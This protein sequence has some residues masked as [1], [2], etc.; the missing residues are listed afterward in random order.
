M[1]ATVTE[2]VAIGGCEDCNNASDPIT[3]EDIKD[4]PSE[5][6]FKVQDKTVTHCFDIRALHQYYEKCGKLENPLN[7]SVFSEETLDEFLK[8]IIQLGLS[9]EGEQDEI[10]QDR[11]RQ[12]AIALNGGEDDDDDFEIVTTVYRHGAH[13]R[14][15]TH[16]H[17]PHGRRRRGNMWSNVSVSSAILDAMGQG[18][19]IARALVNHQIYTDPDQGDRHQ[20]HQPP[21]VP[22]PTELLTPSPQVRNLI[23]PTHLQRRDHSRPAQQHSARTPPEKVEQQPFQHRDYLT[24]SVQ[25]ENILAASR[26]GARP[27][28]RPNDVSDPRGFQNMTSPRLTMSAQ[29]RQP[30]QP[31]IVVRPPLQTFYQ[32]P[33]PREMHQHLAQQ[34]SPPPETRPKPQQPTQKISSRQIPARL[35]E[36]KVQMATAAAES[37][38]P[39]QDM[40]QTSNGEK[41]ESINWVLIALIIAAGVLFLAF[42]FPGLASWFQ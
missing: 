10:R 14:H 9:T 41:D 42:L 16:H 5:F 15:P 11:E 19:S 3:L 17:Q 30:Q 36:V 28:A 25:H 29:N 2:T 33:L 20:R 37:F 4:I 21:S 34:E 7:R 1:S 35:P 6:V 8:R 40:E 32:G 31:P 22:A 39:P 18:N 27:S 13:R 24:Q 23:R 12:E 26:P 38:Q